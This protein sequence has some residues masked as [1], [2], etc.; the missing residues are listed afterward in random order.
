[1]KN[2]FNTPNYFSLFIHVQATCNSLCASVPLSPIR[3]T[4]YSNEKHIRCSWLFFTFHSCSGNLQ[5]TLCL[6]AFV[7]LIE[8]L[9]IQYSTL[10]IQMKNIFDALD[11]FSL[12]IH[13]Q[14][15]CNSLCASVP[16]LLCAFSLP[17]ALRLSKKPQ[18]HPHAPQYCSFDAGFQV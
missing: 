6:C 18:Y 17:L 9:N 16:L 13:V 8:T 3:N 11:Y 7:P 2:I 12:F 1:M 4:Q 15:T 10:N 5:L 14:A